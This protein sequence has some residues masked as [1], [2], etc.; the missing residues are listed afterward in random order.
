MKNLIIITVLCFTP[1][2][3]SETLIVPKA[4]KGSGYKVIETGQKGGLTAGKKRAYVWIKVYKTPV[5]L[6]YEKYQR[7]IEIRRRRRIRLMNKRM[8]FMNAFE[9]KMP[10]LKR[11]KWVRIIKR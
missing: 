7:R 11:W 3:L 8:G 2:V 9:E 6:K 5:E 10:P 1:A 4:P